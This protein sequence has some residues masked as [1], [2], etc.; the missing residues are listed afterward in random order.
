MKRRNVEPPKVSRVDHELEFEPSLQEGS[1]AYS[2]SKDSLGTAS[3]TM[4][5]GDESCASDEHALTEM[6]SICSPALCYVTPNKHRTG[7]LDI[8]NK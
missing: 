4:S 3:T 1:I 2:P 8:D 5:D 7:L 6:P